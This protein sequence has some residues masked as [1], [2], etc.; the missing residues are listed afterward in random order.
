MAK[1]SGEG[2]ESAENLWYLL[3]I[4]K[5]TKRHSKDCDDAAAKLDAV[6]ELDVENGFSPK[7][8]CSEQVDKV[9]R[10][11]IEIDVLQAKQSREKDA[12][13][14]EPIFIVS[15]QYHGQDEDSIE[16]AVVLEMD[17]VDNE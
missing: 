5:R 6:E 10:S 15:C 4:D 2:K 1:S 13:Q 17:V 11:E 7:T 16:E 12:T 14:Q 9:G 8:V 3:K